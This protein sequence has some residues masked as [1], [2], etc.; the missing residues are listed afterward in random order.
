MATIT[1]VNE[2]LRYDALRHALG[3]KWEAL[4]T[5]N[6]RGSPFEWP[7]GADVSVHCFGTFGSG[8]TIKLE[9][10]NEFDQPA[11]DAASWAVLDDI[12]GNELS[13][14]AEGLVPVGPV[15]RWIRPIV[16]AGD[17]TTDL[18][19]FILARRR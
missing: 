13:M 15:C 4:T 16:T 7:L 14:Q 11:D 6:D 17:G 5:T 2:A 1:I 12:F 10:S 19:V 9:G 3:G 8:G 18:D